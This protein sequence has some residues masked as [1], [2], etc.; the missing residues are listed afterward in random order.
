MFCCCF[1]STKEQA[2]HY[3]SQETS[4][5][6]QPQQSEPPT[7]EDAFHLSQPNHFCFFKILTW[8]LMHIHAN[9][10][11]CAIEQYILYICNKKIYKLE[12]VKKNFDKSNR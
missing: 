12:S 10:H 11:K 8:N 7:S 5:E 2:L 3:Q 6:L 1:F 4:T 9:L